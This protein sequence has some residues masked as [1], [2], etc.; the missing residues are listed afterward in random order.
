MKERS[1]GEN[2]R[3]EIARR[4]HRQEETI[5]AEKCSE[6]SQN[7]K[8]IKGIRLFLSTSCHGCGLKVSCK[9]V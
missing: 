9:V 3:K 7:K 4:R 6:C 5:N 8:R 2:A 1:L